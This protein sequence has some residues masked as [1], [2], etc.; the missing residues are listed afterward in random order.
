MTTLDP[1][2]VLRLS[3]AASDLGHYNL[4][5]LLTGAAVASLNRALFTESLPKTDRALVDALAE[6]DPILNEAALDPSLLR[7]IRHARSLIAANQLVLY[8]DS[9]PLYICRVCG[10]V[11][12]QT[13]P[14]HCPVCGA[15]TLVF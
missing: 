9:P 6:I 1:L 7:R 3:R 4:A 15:G 12:W 11:A 8:P 14:E 13:A 10:E 2:S 5:K